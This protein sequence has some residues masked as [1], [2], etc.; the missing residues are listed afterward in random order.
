MLEASLIYV[1]HIGDS[2]GEGCRY[3]LVVNVRIYPP[4]PLS[5]PSSS[6]SSTLI[7]H[8]LKFPGLATIR[9]RIRKYNREPPFETEITK[10]R[11]NPD[12]GEEVEEE[13]E[14]QDSEQE[15]E[16]DDDVK[17]STPAE[18]KKCV[19]TFNVR[20]FFSRIILR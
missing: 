20:F 1:Q 9:Q 19:Y 11:E 13:D 12:Q 2:V 18:T 16:S 8:L 17:S 4:P 5:S 10:Y 14:E 6:S 15:D 3:Y 7:H